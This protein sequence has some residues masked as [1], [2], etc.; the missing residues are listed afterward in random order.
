MSMNGSTC[1]ETCNPSFRGSLLCHINRL[2]Y[3][4]WMLENILQSHSQSVSQSHL[5]II[6]LY[7]IQPSKNMYMLVCHGGGGGGCLSLHM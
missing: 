5:C 2:A 4:V 1:S 6:C 3:A 7:F